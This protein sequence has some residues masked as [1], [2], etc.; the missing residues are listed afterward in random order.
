LSPH[1]DGQVRAIF[2]R[3]SSFAAYAKHIF[4]IGVLSSFLAKFKMAAMTE[5]AN[6]WKSGEMIC[7]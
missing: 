3:A 7:N 5:R 4:A 2:R 1:N 6:M